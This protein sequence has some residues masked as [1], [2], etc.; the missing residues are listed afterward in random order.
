[1]NGL[2]IKILNKDLTGLDT[3]EKK[4]ME[5]LIKY[6]END[7]FSP[8]E[9]V[10]NCMDYEIAELWMDVNEVMKCPLYS[11]SL[12][13]EFLE[14]RGKDILWISL[15][16]SLVLA[17]ILFGIS[18]NYSKYYPTLKDVFYLSIILVVQN[19]VLILT[20]KSIFGRWKDDYYKEKLEW[21][22]FRNFLSDFAMIKKY[23][24]EDIS[25]WKEWLIYGT[26]LGVGDKV[27]EAMKSLNIDIPEV[28]IAPDVYI[29]YNLMYSSIYDS[30]T[31]ITEKSSG[32]FGGGIGGGFGVGGGFGGGGAGA[33]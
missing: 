24:P 1:M 32:N 28:D 14:T 5:F 8:D 16:I 33:R 20:P 18:T 15:A 22:A 23:S 30:Y 25:I 19:I 29:T 10:S 7:V 4:V 13:K 9:V 27:V 26:A 2:K 12:V 11:S 6:S 21:E 31:A 3:Y 17:L